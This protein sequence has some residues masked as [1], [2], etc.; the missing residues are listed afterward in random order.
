MTLKERMQNGM[1][2]YEHG[3]KDPVDIQQEKE[4]EAERRRCKEIMFDYNRHQTQRGREA[5]RDS[6]GKYWATAEIMYSLKI[7]YICPMAPT[8]IWESISTRI[9]IW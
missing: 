9:S 2:F 5:Q 8:F 3:H 7:R 4:L 1:L 6:E